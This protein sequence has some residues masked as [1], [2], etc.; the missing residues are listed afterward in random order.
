MILSEQVIDGRRFRIVVQEWYG[1]EW[2]SANARDEAVRQMVRE[3]K[4]QAESG[5]KGGECEKCNGSGAMDSGATEAW[6]EW[7]KVPCDLCDGTG[8]PEKGGE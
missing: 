6:G 4:E 2:G 7:I 3:L 5:Q 8:Q 1:V